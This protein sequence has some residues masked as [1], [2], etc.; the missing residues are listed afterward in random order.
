MYYEKISQ[1]YSTERL[2]SIPYSAGK[3]SNLHIV[4]R[5]TSN[6]GLENQLSLFQPFSYSYNACVI[7]FYSS[8]FKTFWQTQDSKVEWLWKWSRVPL[9]QFCGFY[10]NNLSEKKLF[11]RILKRILSAYLNGLMISIIKQIT[12]KYSAYFMWNKEKNWH[13]N[14][15]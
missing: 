6:C 2:F 8:R 14:Y 10:F 7:L 4:Y 13:D 1:K 5:I 11:Q 3:Y 12:L 15:A 9:I